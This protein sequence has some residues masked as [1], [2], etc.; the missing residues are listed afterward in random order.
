MKK[1]K[2][3][4]VILTFSLI[5]SLS[6][7][8]YGCQNKQTLAPFVTEVQSIVMQGENDTHKLKAV[9]GYKTENGARAY[10]L[11]VKLLEK[12]TDNATY[13]LNFDYADKSYSVNFTLNPV[14]NT[15]TAKV[16]LDGFTQNS[17]S[18][19]VSASSSSHQITLNSIIPENACDYV[20]AVDSL[21]VSQPALIDLYRDE[22]GN[23]NGSIKARILVKN[24]KPYWYIGLINA[25]GNEK[26]LLVDGISLEVL[27]IRDIF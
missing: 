5:L 1:L 2:I 7:F 23:F 16:R 12:H 11:I 27:A 25:N 6:T 21:L 20:T 9:Y 19:K 10:Y 8:S 17:L 26:A 22:Y 13:T 15:L 24:D 3:L 18:V 14:T 4:S